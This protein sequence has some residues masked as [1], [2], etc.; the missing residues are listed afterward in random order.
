MSALVGSATWQHTDDVDHARVVIEREPHAQLADAQTPFGAAL[1][2][3]DIAR[4][5]VLDE[6]VEC[7][8]DAPG[9]GRIEAPNVTPSA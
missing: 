8:D 9:V 6:A 5:R 2:F 7:C 3:A 1:E 4:A